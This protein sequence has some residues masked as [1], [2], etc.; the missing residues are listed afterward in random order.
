MLVNIIQTFDEGSRRWFAGESQDVPREV[1]LRW[2][3]DGKAAAATGGTQ[4]APRWFSGPQSGYRTV[5]FGDSMTSQYYVDSLPSAASYNPDTGLLTL[6]QSGHQLA[7]GWP[8]DLFHRGYPSL[9]AH[10][11]LPVSVVNSSTWT[12]QLNPSEH[13]DLPSGALAGGIF[14][15]APH[16]IASNGMFTWLQILSGQRFNVVY[17]GAQSGD[18]TTDALARIERHCLVYRPDVVFMQIPGINDTTPN[19]ASWPDAEI[20]ENQKLICRRILDVG[21]CMV[22]LNMTPCAAGQVRATKQN[23]ARVRRIN[24]ALFEWA[25][26]YP[27][28]I[29]FDAFRQIVNPADTDGLAHGSLLHPTDFIHYSVRG[30]HKVAKALWAQIQHRFPAPAD[31]LPVSVIDSFGGAAITL[32]S[33]TRAG[34]VVSSAT[35]AHG[36]RD[37]ER[38]K[39]TGGTGNVFNDYVTVR[40]S[41]VNACSF[42]H[43][44]PDGA[45]AGTVLLSRC[46]QLQVNP[47]LTVTTGGTLAGGATGTAPAG[48]RVN[49]LAG[50]PTAVASAQARADGFG[51]DLQVVITPAAAGN[52]VEITLA[53][54]T[55]TLVNVVKGGRRYRFACHVSLAGVVAS[56]LEEFNPQLFFTVAGASHNAHAMDTY[57]TA[58]IDEDWTGVVQTAEIVMPPGEVTNFTWNITPRFSAAGSALTIRIGRLSL[59]EVE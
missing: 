42:E 24:D 22:L 35:T 16:R 3:V 6:T 44:G 36:F 57:N 10:R 51:N 28:I 32:T 29:R 12:V 26:D 39:V 9:R 11:R 58:M 1:A 41:G 56:N 54:T 55:S 31:S 34:G 4:D 19:E 49:I 17:N 27:G 23:T 20:L 5:L 25:R 21:A 53:G 7:S 48:T 45:I 38:A 52:R 37:G 2:V 15:R 50:S 43:A 18:I 47:T 14:A 13:S 40:V 59:V 46:S 30:A 8:M 33:P